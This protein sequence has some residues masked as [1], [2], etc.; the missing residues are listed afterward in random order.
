MTCVWESETL[1]TT[2]KKGSQRQWKA[3]VHDLGGGSHGV[4]RI[5]GQVDGKLSK[6][7]RIWGGPTKPPPGSRQS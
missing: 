3:E 7:E 2:D 1:Y 4:R 6:M 5:F